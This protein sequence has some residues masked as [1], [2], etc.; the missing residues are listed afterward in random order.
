MLRE[1]EEILH[2]SLDFLPLKSYANIV[3]GNALR[4]NWE[5]VVSKDKLSYIIGNPPF[6][7]ANNVDKFQKEELFNLFGDN[8]KAGLLDYVT[9]WYY[10]ATQYM[11]GT[12]IKTAFVSTN[13]ITQGE[14]VSIMWKPITEMGARI[15]FAH[16]TFIWDSEANEKAHVHVVIIGFST[17][18]NNDNNYIYDNDN[19]TKAGNINF[20]LINAD[21]V[22][23]DRR[24]KPLCDVP[25]I[26]KGCQPTDGGNLIIEADEYEDFIKREPA[27]KKYIKRLV[28]SKEYIN[29]LDRYCLWLVNVSPKEL[30]SMP[31][32]MERIEKVREMR[33]NSTDKAT[34]KLAETPT[35]FRET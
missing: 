16:R 21:N 35:L 27:A 26:T 2:Q 18:K 17:T 10:K 12:H 4:I 32:V 7:G 29:N 25:E 28:G 5:D 13:S 9:G 15:N 14:Q 1:T 11:Q 20:Y 33:L 30:H 22:F 8:S 19:I 23:I 31:L 24:K 34:R 3:H 6:I